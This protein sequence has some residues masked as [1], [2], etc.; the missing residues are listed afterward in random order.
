MKKS[1]VYS[2]RLT[3]DLKARLENAARVQEVSVSRLLEEIVE[4]WLEE[5]RPGAGDEERQ[6][7]RQREAAQAFGNIQGGDPDRSRRAR[8]RVRSRLRERR[9]D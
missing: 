4:E 5:H 3:P 8:D 7:R 2:W 6:R 1:E 9:G